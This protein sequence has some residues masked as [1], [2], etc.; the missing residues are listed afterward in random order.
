MA[1]VSV[2]PSELTVI[3]TELET[4]DVLLTGDYAQKKEVIK[5]ED[6]IS[7]TGSEVEDMDLSHVPQHYHNRIRAMLHSHEEMWSGHLGTIETT[8]HR[9]ELIPGARPQRS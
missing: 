1:I 3:H 7:L 6:K 2:C 4:E 8:K 5:N 9:I